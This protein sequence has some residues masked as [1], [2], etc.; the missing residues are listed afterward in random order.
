MAVDMYTMEEVP[1]PIDGNELINRTVTKIVAGG[2]HATCITT[3]GELFLW[4]MAYK[5]TQ[6]C[7]PKYLMWDV[8]M[9][10]PWHC[11]T[12]ICSMDE[13]KEGREYT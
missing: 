13:A 3:S 11:P 1:F 8:G 5:W 2:S 7:I 12:I 10:S 4:G 9:T 6:S